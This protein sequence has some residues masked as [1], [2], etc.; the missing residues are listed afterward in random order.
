MPRCRSGQLARRPD[1]LTGCRRLTQRLLRQRGQ[2]LVQDPTPS[3]PGRDPA[4]WCHRAARKDGDWSFSTHRQGTCSG[5]HGVG[6]WCRI[7]AT[8]SGEERVDTIPPHIRDDVKE[9]LARYVA[10]SPDALL[11]APAA[12]GGCH[13]NDRVPTKT[14]SKSCKG[15]GREDLSAH[16]S[17]RFAGT[18]TLR[19]L[20]WPKTWRVVVYAEGRVRNRRRRGSLFEFVPLPQGV[21]LSVLAE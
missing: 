2:R 4:C 9:H 18:K 13:L 7:D 3:Q 16:D 6:Q 8:K 14:G 1:P 15:G 10:S 21:D 12:M 5:H 17:R 11:F 20:R 19:C